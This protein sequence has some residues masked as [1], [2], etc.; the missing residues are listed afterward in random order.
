MFSRF[1]IASDR[2]APKLNIEEEL[3]IIKIRNFSYNHNSKFLVERYQ[4]ACLG[5][6]VHPWTTC[7]Q[8]DWVMQKGH[9]FRSPPMWVE[10]AS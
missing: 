7:G 4:L 1:F 2:H 5:S 9:S 10:V 8:E 6:N 3:V